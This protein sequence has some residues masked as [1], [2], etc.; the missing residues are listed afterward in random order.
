MSQWVNFWA[1]SLYHYSET[2]VINLLKIVILVPLLY[3]TNGT[4]I[5]IYVY[6]W[7]IFV[8]DLKKI[9]LRGN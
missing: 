1:K 6:L 7:F 4:R 3:G 8:V 9:V 5:N 2:N